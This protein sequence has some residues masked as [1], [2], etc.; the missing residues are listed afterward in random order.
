MWKAKGSE[1]FEA[2]IN[3]C[4]DN[5]EYL[6]DQLQRRSDFQLVFDSKPEHCNVCFWYIPPS[7][8]CLPAGPEKEAKLHQLA[9]QIKA[10]MMEKGSA[11]IGYQPLGTKVNFFRCV[12][13]NPA[14]KKE[15]VDFLLDQIVQL[16][17]DL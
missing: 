2:Q 17:H 13:S 9:P 12:L 10:R 3:K 4:L 14:T 11:M 15:D 5:A 16:G 6:Y 7:V 1:G 8:T